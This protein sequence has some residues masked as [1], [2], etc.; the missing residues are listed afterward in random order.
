MSSHSPK[1]CAWSSAG[2]SRGSV[3]GTLCSKVFSRSTYAASHDQSISSY[4]VL[5]SSFA[6]TF[7]SSISARLSSPFASAEESFFHLFICHFVGE[8]MSALSFTFM[9]TFAFSASLKSSTNSARRP[10]HNFSPSTFCL[11]ILPEDLCV[12]F[13]FRERQYFWW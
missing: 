3:L 13:S 6:S 1:S 7:T 8:V 4:G 9:I 11:S 5:F 10:V 12:T 2:A